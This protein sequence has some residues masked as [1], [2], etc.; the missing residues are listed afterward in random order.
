MRPRSKTELGRLVRRYGGGAAAAAAANRNRRNRL[1]TRQTIA[2][3][4]VVHT[5]MSSRY[6]SA[7]RCVR[8][9]RR[10]PVRQRDR[11]TVNNNCHRPHRVAYHHR[12]T[13]KHRA[14]VFVG[15]VA[16]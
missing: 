3:Y 13:L 4:T 2:E 11:G 7:R 15:F 1:T 16:R 6:I 9:R 12:H 10:R 14:N 5:Q 8:R